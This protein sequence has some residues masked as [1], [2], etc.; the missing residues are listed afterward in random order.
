[1]KEVDLEQSS[2]P[3]FA[4]WR[5]GVGGFLG[6]VKDAMGGLLYPRVCAGCGRGVVASGRA[7]L[8]EGCFG[9]LRPLR[10]PICEKCGEPYAGEV[11]GPF[12]CSNCADRTFSFDYA[13]AA[14]RG[15]GLMRE[16]IHRFK[17]QRAFYLGRV[18]GELMEDVFWDGRVDM[19]DDWVL[20]P[21]PLHAR[22]KREREFNQAAE[23]CRVLR[24]RHDWPVVG[25]LKRTRYTS[26]Q[27]SLDRA[28][29]LANMEGAFDMRPWGGWRGR[30]EGR[31]V[32]LV[33]DVLT[34]GATAHGCARVLKERAGADKVVVLTLARS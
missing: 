30:L 2:V 23:L 12:R 24:R 18:L 15:E 26:V 7:G 9:D 29:R 11:S 16:L 14:Y 5:E 34:T 6:E 21:V 31:S 19:S 4:S 10:A 33:D 3:V 27:V 25:V 8:C 13:V 22:R 32:F 17:Y 28:E 20:V 1:M